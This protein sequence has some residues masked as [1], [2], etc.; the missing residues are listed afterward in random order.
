MRK[1]TYTIIILLSFLFRANAQ[2]GTLYYRDY[3]DYYSEHAK[4][5]VLTKDLKFLKDGNY[6]FKGSVEDF[7]FLVNQKLRVSPENLADID[8]LYLEGRIKGA[9]KVGL[10]KIRY[11]DK[12]TNKLLPLLVS[13]RF[14][15]ET[16][17]ANDEELN[18]LENGKIQEMLKKF[19]G[20]RLVR[21][22]NEYINIA[23]KNHAIDSLD[24][25][26]FREE[27]ALDIS[28]KDGSVKYRYSSR[29]SCPEYTVYISRNSN[30]LNKELT[31]IIKFEKS[32]DT[33]PGK[34]SY[35]E[36]VIKET[37]ESGKLLKL[38]ISYD[39]KNNGNAYFSKFLNNQNY[40]E[41]LYS[42]N[43]TCQ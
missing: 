21:Y 18:Y 37:F 9:V 30:N 40:Q 27:E 36:A 39:T 8:T 14:S 33:E 5:T 38:T 34:V 31:T 20:E 1:L 12:A 28:R 2:K 7:Y 11:K 6:S 24:G 42:Y 41:I 23:F 43:T 35:Y 22:G 13:P 29:T 16:V 10:W 25:N 17:K 4:S 32:V 19:A 15:I 3:V 26:H